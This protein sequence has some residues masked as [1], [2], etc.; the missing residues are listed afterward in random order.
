MPSGLATSTV[1]VSPGCT[2]LVG[3]V[4]GTS[5]FAFG[6]PTSDF[7]GT[8]LSANSVAFGNA[9][10]LYALGFLPGAVAIT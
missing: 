9:V 8:S 4:N 3:T 2:P 1:V 6:M 5:P 7:A 10:S